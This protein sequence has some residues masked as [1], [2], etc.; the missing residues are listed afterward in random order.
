MQ[1]INLKTILIVSFILLVLDSIYISIF[2]N[3]FKNQVYKVQKKPLQMNLPTTIACYIL[4]IFGL[5]YF[6]IKPKKSVT[7]AFL[8]GLFVY[9]VYE[10]TTI[11]LLKDWEFKTVIIDTIWGGI[12]FATTTHLTYKF[13]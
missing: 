9:G 13:I 10:L 4:L 12:L 11:S 8:L 3:H 5:Y 1:D 7:E 2:S 6:I